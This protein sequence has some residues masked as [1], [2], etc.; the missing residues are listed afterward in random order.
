M[1]LDLKERLSLINQFLIL[2]KLYPEE[3]VHYQKHRKALEEGYT[4]HYDWIVQNLWEEM[5]EDECREVL[6]I[7]D[8]YRSII[9][10]RNDNASDL[11]EDEVSFKGFDGNNETNQLAYARYVIEDLGRFDEI[12]KL[13][14]GIHNSHIPML[15]KYRRMLSKWNEYPSKHSM[16]HEQIINLLEV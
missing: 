9:F 14:A 15:H 5:T 11:S 10:S 1:E 16:S 7:L 4:L 3:A 8:M 2:E 6:D 12:K 13:G